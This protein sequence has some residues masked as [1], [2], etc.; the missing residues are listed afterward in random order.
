MALTTSHA[1]EMVFAF[2]IIIQSFFYRTCSTAHSPTTNSSSTF[3]SALLLNSARLR[4]NLSCMKWR[5]RSSMWKDWKTRD[6]RYEF[7]HSDWSPLLQIRCLAQGPQNQGGTASR[8]RQYF[9]IYSETITSLEA[10]CKTLATAS[11]ESSL[12][13]QQSREALNENQNLQRAMAEL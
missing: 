10:K 4:M 5:L 1:L 6:K 12:F 9:P 8:K 7:Y 2:G 11:Q 3:R 13:R